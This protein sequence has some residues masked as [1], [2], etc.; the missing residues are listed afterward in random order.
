MKHQEETFWA[1]VISLVFG[2]SLHWP[3]P[4]RILTVCLAAAVLIQVAI[5]VIAAFRKG[6]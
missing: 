1:M 4:L 6:C 5:Q 3:L 2:I